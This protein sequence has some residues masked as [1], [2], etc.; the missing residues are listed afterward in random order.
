LLYILLCNIL[1]NKLKQIDLPL[2]MFLQGAERLVQHLHQH[3]IP[4]ALATGSHQPELLLKTSRH[5][6]LFSLFSHVVCSSD[7]PDVKNGKPHPDCFLVAAQRF[8]DPPSP[9]K[10]YISHVLYQRSYSVPVRTS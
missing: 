10:V 7:D 4:M 8:A 5:R 6:T 3:D 1:Y 2:C 9:E